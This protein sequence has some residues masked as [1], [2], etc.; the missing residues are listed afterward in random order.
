MIAYD[1][2]S[3]SDTSWF[4]SALSFFNSTNNKILVTIALVLFLIIVIEIIALW[5]I[6]TKAKKPG[7]ISLIPIVNVIY[8][9]KIAKMKAYHLVLMCIPV[10]GLYFWYRMSMN[11]AQVFK[12]KPLFGWGLFFLSPIFLIILSFGDAEYDKDY[13]YTEVEE[14]PPTKEVIAPNRMV[15]EDYNQGLIFD[16]SQNVDDVVIS[17]PITNDT[18]EMFD[19]GMN[20]EGINMTFQDMSEAAANNANGVGNIPEIGASQMGSEIGMA[21]SSPEPPKSYSAT[22]NQFFMPESNQNVNVVSSISPQESIVNN[23]TKF[24]AEPAKMT[25]EQLLGLQPTETPPSPT[26]APVVQSNINVDNVFGMQLQE[27]PQPPVSAPV[28]SM[29][30]ISQQIP[31]ISPQTMSDPKPTENNSISFDNISNPPIDIA[32][33]PQVSTNSINSSAEPQSSTEI[34]QDINQILGMNPDNLQAVPIKEDTPEIEKKLSEGGDINSTADDISKILGIDPNELEAVPIMKNEVPVI[35]EINITQSN[36]TS[37]MSVSDFPPEKENNISS[38][39][40]TI[41]PT[42]TPLDIPAL[43]ESASTSNTSNLPV[44]DSENSVN[45]I[46]INSLLGLPEP[47]GATD[48]SDEK[49]SQILPSAQEISE[50]EVRKVTNIETTT[51]AMINNAAAAANT[52][53]ANSPALTGF[54]LDNFLSNNQIDAEPNQTETTTPVGQIQSFVGQLEPTS[55]ERK[56]EVQTNFIEKEEKVVEKDKICAN[57]GAKLPQEAK[58]CYLCGKPV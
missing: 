16:P 53:P 17:A 57:C 58:F 28:P 3:Y 15:F 26:E 4:M 43:Q 2:F 52:I 8:L 32:N 51:P 55:S 33:L 7:F 40:S 5:G 36:T 47:N 25:V 44:S 41:S 30:P 22:P 1:I 50:P 48:I 45:E 49:E 14:T 38:L 11:L 37:N 54:N 20:E 10:V 19:K 21:T 18:Y 29:D 56:E 23:S 24:G 34:S 9:L 39:D 13:Y 6:F 31:N 35:P 46:D 27:E 42:S 12:K